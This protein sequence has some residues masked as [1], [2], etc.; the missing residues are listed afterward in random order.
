MAKEKLDSLII[1][2]TQAVL[3]KYILTKDINT[4]KTQGINFIGTN[5]LFEKVFIHIFFFKII[6]FLPFLRI[7]LIALFMNKTVLK[8]LK[9][10]N[11]LNR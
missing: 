5:F 7:G 10:L 4:Q 11:H 6:S 1:Q 3:H 9:I 8:T 2:L